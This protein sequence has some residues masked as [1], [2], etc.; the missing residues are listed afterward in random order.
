MPAA[1]AGS[2]ERKEE[3]VRGARC[4]GPRG[5]AAARPRSLTW[6]D[7]LALVPHAGAHGAGG[8]PARPSRERQR[9]RVR[10]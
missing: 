7:Q 5:G 6:V 10:V 1:G 3:R 4:A 8:G 2:E 9:R